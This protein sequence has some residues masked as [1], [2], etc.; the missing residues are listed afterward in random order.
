MKFV[1]TPKICMKV[2][3]D[4]SVIIAALLS[5]EGGSAQIFEFCEAGVLKGYISKDVKKEC[6]EVIKRKFPEAETDFKKLLKIVH[7]KLMKNVKPTFLRNAKSWISHPK[8]SKILAA[9]KQ[10]EVNYLLTLDIKHFIKDPHVS[11]KANIK[12]LTPGD[13]LKI[14]RKELN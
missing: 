12:I 11:E 14:F 8:D 10:A 4:S 2:F 1:I 7:L 6:E 13:F 3:L 9:A 5:P